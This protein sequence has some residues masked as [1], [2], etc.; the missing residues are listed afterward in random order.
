M[1]KVLAICGSPRKGNTEF[2]LN[3]ILNKVKSN[4]ELILLRDYNI[5]HCEGTANCSKTKNCCIKDDMNKLYKKLEE[6]DI[7]I[8]GSPAYWYSVTGIFKDFMDRCTPYYYNKKLGGKK[9]ILITVGQDE[10]KESI[11][12]VINL[13][14]KFCKE[15]EIKII[16]DYL[17]IGL[18]ANDISKDKKVIKDLEKIGEKL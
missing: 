6:A 12:P 17:A 10:T 13:L 4:K 5:K 15:L 18:E 8:F 7:I 14:K 11:I 3:T 9:A 16:K 2:M 1:N